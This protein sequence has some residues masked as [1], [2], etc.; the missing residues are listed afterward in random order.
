MESGH[1]LTEID[2]VDAGVQHPELSDG[3][4]I[5]VTFLSVLESEVIRVLRCAELCLQFPGKE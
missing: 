4:A 5:A 1:V 2:A 3:S